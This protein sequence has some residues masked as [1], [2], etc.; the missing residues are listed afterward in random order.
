MI[1]RTS[2]GFP[3]PAG[4]ASEFTRAAALVVVKAMGWERAFFPLAAR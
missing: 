2:S 1:A 4:R 3:K